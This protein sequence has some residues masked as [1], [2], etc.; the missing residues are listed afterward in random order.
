[1]LSGND[2]RGAAENKKSGKT[3]QKKMG[4]RFLDSLTRLGSITEM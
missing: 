1:M 2:C 3:Q 4:K